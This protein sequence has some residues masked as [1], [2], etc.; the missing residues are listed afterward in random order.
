MDMYRSVSPVSSPRFCDQATDKIRSKLYVKLSAAW[1]DHYPM[2]TRLKNVYTVAHRN[3]VDSKGSQDKPM[4]N[5]FSGPDPSLGVAHGEDHWFELANATSDKHR[6][7]ITKRA[8]EA[9]PDSAEQPT[10]KKLKMR[11]GMQKSMADVFG[12]FMT[13]PQT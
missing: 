13:T 4:L 10:S 1:Y 11:M 9:C 12:D 7:D 6:N 5:I 2:S 8:P 3:D